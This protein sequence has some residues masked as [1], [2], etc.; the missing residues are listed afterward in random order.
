[1]KNTTCLCDRPGPSVR[2]SLKSLKVSICLL[3]N[4][5]AGLSRDTSTYISEMF[6]MSLIYSDRKHSH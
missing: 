1:M 5:S 2:L 4:E 6:K 3:S